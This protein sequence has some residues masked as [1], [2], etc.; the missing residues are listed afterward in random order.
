MRRGLDSVS[1]G[2]RDEG[3]ALAGVDGAM[4]RPMVRRVVDAHGRSDGKPLV[5]CR[6]YGIIVVAGLCEKIH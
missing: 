1:A 3:S 4:R 6:L 5:S 2:R